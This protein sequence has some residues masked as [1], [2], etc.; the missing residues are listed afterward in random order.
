MDWVTGAFLMMRKEVFQKTG[1]FDKDYFMYVEEV[2]LCFRAKKLGWE[3]WY[4]PKW[5]IIHYG[6]ASST[7]EFPLI[8]EV[9]SLKTFYAKHMNPLQSFVLR[10]L[11]KFGALLRIFVFGLFKGG[12]AA[13]TYAKIFIT[14]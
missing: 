13:K 1:G 11:I 12:A 9:K 10:V 8:N 2:D 5:N 7:S 3:V 6:G 4:L 14:A